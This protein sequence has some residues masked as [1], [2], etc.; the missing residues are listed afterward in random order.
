MD[1]VAL[2]ETGRV[3][4]NR[5]W[6]D[7]RRV[8]AQPARLGF[9]IVGRLGP[10][11]LAGNA[12]SVDVS[13]ATAI[14]R[15]LA[16]ALNIRG[17]RLVAATPPGFHPGRAARV[18]V[19]GIP[20]GFVGEIHP[21]TARAYD[22]EG[23]V[24][25]GELDLGPLTAPPPSWQFEE[26]SVYPPVVFDLA[27]DASD[28]LPAADL[29]NAVS[30]AAPGVI[31]SVFVFDEYRGPGVAPA[32]KGLAIRF[33]LRARDRTLSSGEIDQHRQAIIKA[34]EAIGAGLRKS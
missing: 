22:L 21:L 29:L 14:W 34:A 30:A 23:R 16:D 33:T 24:A 10:R 18:T 28:S 26:P 3:F 4:F 25:A 6:D 2:F 13:T 12:R 11:D 5:P 19:Q 31:E 8:P 9:A 32:R 20:I 17:S 1:D 27:F 15:T 7:D